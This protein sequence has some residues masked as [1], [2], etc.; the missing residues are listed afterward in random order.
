[1]TSRF[2]ERRSFRNQLKT[3]LDLRG[4]TDLTWSE[5]FSSQELDEIVPPFIGVTVIDF[6]KDE[7]EMGG[8]PS[9]N[10]LY[11]RRV[12]ANLY[13]ESADRVDALCDDIGDF[14]DLEV[15]II[16]DNNNNILG[17]MSSDT[18]SIVSDTFDPDLEGEKNLMW[19]G[20]VACMYEV[21]YPDG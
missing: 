10:K 1:M 16:K 19:E 2:F 8:N 15:I 11:A 5:S 4:W 6:G 12:Q 7:L 9:K 13:M 14:M 21:Y 17:S 20:V 3:Y 18:A